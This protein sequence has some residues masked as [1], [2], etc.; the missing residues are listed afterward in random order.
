MTPQKKLLEIEQ[1]C[2]KNEMLESIYG[3]RTIDWLIARVKQ[4]EKASEAVL[5]QF[6]FHGASL[7]KLRHALASMPE[8][9]E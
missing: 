7:D 2:G 3:P 8:E 5:T 4:L 6:R 9:I 1:E